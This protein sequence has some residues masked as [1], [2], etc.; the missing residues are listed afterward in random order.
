MF[1]YKIKKYLLLSLLLITTIIALL[2]FILSFRSVNIN[3]LKEYILKNSNISAN[4]KNVTTDNIVIKI[5]LLSNQIN[6]G[7][8]NVQLNDLNK[9]FKKIEAKEVSL[10]LTLSKLIKKEV[11]INTLNINDAKVHIGTI[12]NFFYQIA[13]LNSNSLV[14]QNSELNIFDRFFDY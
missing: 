2:L 3:Y 1:K 11:F 14:E 13:K 6:L 5:N 10:D 12:D 4:F 8:G 9:N 7:I